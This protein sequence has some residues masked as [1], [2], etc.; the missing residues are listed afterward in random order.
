[1][2]TA[3]AATVMTTTATVMTTTA[4]A[5]VPAHDRDRTSP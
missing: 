5:T 2:A 4:T 1:M 3:P